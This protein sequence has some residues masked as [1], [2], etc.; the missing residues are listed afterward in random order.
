MAS[1]AI[2]QFAIIFGDYSLGSRRSS[3]RAERPRQFTPKE[4]S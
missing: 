2:N 4:A 1:Y 3:T